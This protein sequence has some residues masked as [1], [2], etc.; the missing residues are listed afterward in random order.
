MSARITKRISTRIRLA[1][2]LVLS[3]LAAGCSGTTGPQTVANP[4]PGV[5]VPI[6]RAAVDRHDT[7]VIPQLI[8]DL[9]DDDPA[10]RFYANDGLQKLTGQD[11]NYRFYDDADARKPSIDRWRAWLGQHQGEI[12]QAKP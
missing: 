9:N 7:S 12:A 10:I 6:I 4:D 1:A 5:K 2:W 11:F 8:D 3:S